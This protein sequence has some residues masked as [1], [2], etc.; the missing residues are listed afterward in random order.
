M[1]WFTVFVIVV[2][3]LSAPFETTSTTTN[4]RFSWRIVKTMRFQPGVQ[5][6]TLTVYNPLTAQCDA[7][8]L[9]TASNS[10]IDTTALRQKD[11]RWLALSRDLI[12]RWGGRFCYG[13]TVV[14][15]AND[16]AI[17]GVWI[18]KDT[19]HKRFKLH[20][21]LLFHSHIRTRGR[22]RNV[23]IFKVETTVTRHFD[24]DPQRDAD[25]R[26]PVLITS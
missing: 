14:V 17:D 19:M 4:G 2:G 21:D 22:W 12:R 6:E 26:T 25:S 18:V 13:D 23:K 5:L 15:V 16:P 24:S 20:G 10:F 1:K 3:L 9:I 7:T 11:V 8:P